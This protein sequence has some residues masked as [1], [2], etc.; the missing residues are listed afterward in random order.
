MLGK[1]QQQTFFI[2]QVEI[3]KA[4]LA[5]KSIAKHTLRQAYWVNTLNDSISLLIT[6]SAYTERRLRELGITCP[7]VRFV[8]GVNTAALRLATLSAS[9]PP[10]PKLGLG[11][12]P[13]LA[14]VNHFLCSTV[15][16]L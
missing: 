2:G 8:G 9:I 12:C 10:L 15:C 7:F 3:V 4:E 14:W 13:S 6:N 5:D 11:L 1:G 16:S